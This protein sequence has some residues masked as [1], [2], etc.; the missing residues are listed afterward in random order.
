VP[1]RV[2]WRQ[3]HLVIRRTTQLGRDIIDRSRIVQVG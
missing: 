2:P 3:G 1:A